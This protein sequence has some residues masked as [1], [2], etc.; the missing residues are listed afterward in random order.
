MITLEDVWWILHISIRGELVTYDHQL[1]IA[2]IERIFV[3]DVYI[4]DGFM[5]WED[6]E[7]LYE[8]L[9]AVLSRIV[10]GLLCPDRHSHGLATG[11]GQV[12]EQMVT[13]GTHYV[14]G[15]CVLAH[16]YKDLHEAVY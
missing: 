7:A 2:T 11:W 9:P 8:P 4:E 16:L 15:P 3:E 1:G 12:I 5:A 6:I 10:G 13:E 14:W